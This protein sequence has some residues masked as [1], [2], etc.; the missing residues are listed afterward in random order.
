M[1]S[2]SGSLQDGTEIPGLTYG[3]TNVTAQSD[4]D[5]S[6]SVLALLLAALYLSGSRRKIS[7][8][9]AIIQGSWSEHRWMLEQVQ[10]QPMNSGS[11][12]DGGGPEGSDSGDLAGGGPAGGNG[13]SGKGTGP[14]YSSNKFLMSGVRYG[15]RKH[16]LMDFKYDLEGFRTPARSLLCYHAELPT[17][18]ERSVLELGPRG[19]RIAGNRPSIFR[20]TVNRR[21]QS[22][23]HVFLKTYPRHLADSLCRELAVYD[24]L[25]ELSC[26]PRLLAVV[27]EPHDDYAGLLLEDVGTSL[28]QGDWDK[29]Q[30]SVKDRTAIY[31]AMEA[32]HNSG[33]VHRDM[34][35]RNVVRGPT[36]ALSVIDFELATVGH[37][38]TGVDC[39]ELRNLRAA[40]R[41]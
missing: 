15:G 1:P 36:G 16:H 26:V 23:H 39:G 7:N 41:L 27:V 6:V 20:G 19:T 14:P 29:V 11:G 4:A 35:P 37:D 5:P 22:D 34:A 18:E 31:S 17:T 40:L 10:D 3:V 8:L 21:E 25:R 38:C 30:L 24:A 32:I 9:S 28:G 13:R 2:V 33:V 12:S